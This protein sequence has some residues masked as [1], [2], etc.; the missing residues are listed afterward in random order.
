MRLT[1]YPGFDI[2]KKQHQELM[3]QVDALQQKVD[4][5]KVAISFELLHFLRNWLIQHIND[6]DKRFGRHFQKAGLA[7]YANWS[8]DVEKTMKKKKWW[9]K[10][11]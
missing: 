6:S 7:T 5:E 8:K 10:F 3:Q 4:K 9:W 11:W 1:H 2:H